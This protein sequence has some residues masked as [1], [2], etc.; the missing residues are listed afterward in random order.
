MASGLSFRKEARLRKRCLHPAPTL[1]FSNYPIPKY[2]SLHLSY[3]RGCIQTIIPQQH[4]RTREFLQKI[5]THFVTYGSK[6]RID[7]ALSDARTTSTLTNV[8]ARTDLL[9]PGHRA[10]EFSFDLARASQSVSKMRKF[11]D[12]PA[13]VFAYCRTGTRCTILWSRCRCSTHT[14]VCVHAQMYICTR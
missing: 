11:P 9:L 12:L 5:T 6:T 14:C 8:R 2:S 4:S 13:P 10:V 7:R 3:L 1:S